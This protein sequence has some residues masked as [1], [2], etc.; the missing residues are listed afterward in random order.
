MP[1]FSN[2][3]EDSPEIGFIRISTRLAEGERVG[4]HVEFEGV[5]AEQAIGHLTLV[6][7]RMKEE[8]SYSWNAEAEF[9]LTIDMDCPEC[10]EHIHLAPLEPDEE[11]EDGSD[12]ED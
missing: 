9:S 8:A 10:G 4:T 2:V 7:D 3:P 1:E 6:L 11:D 5:S 12:P